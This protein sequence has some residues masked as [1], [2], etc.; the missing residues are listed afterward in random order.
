MVSERSAFGGRSVSAVGVAGAYGS[1]GGSVP[2]DS[3]SRAIKSSSSRDELKLLCLQVTRFS[4]RP[5]SASGAASLRNFTTYVRRLGY[6]GST[7]SG[8]AVS[9]FTN[10]DSLAAVDN[11]VVSKTSPFDRN[12]YCLRAEAM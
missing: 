6:V 3:M 9:G 8:M 5:Q 2:Q 4:R 1:F 11:R 12:G 7:L 10:E